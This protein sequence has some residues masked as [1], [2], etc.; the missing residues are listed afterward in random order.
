MGITAQ[1]MDFLSEGIK[2][3]KGIKY[4]DVAFN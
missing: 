2:E 1:G 3:L 4:A